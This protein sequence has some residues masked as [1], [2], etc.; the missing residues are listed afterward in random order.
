MT[1]K[2]PDCKRGS[3]FRFLKRVGKYYCEYCGKYFTKEE[4]ANVS[5]NI[6]G[7]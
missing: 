5:H 7:N 1:L 2:C 6:V 4:V 3:R